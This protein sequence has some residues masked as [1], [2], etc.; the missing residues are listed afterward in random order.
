[1]GNRLILLVIAGLG[2]PTVLSAQTKDAGEIAKQ[3]KAIEAAFDK[4]NLKPAFQETDHLLVYAAMPKDKLKPVAELSQKSFLA[5]AKALNVEK[6]DE[7]FKGKMAA[8]LIPERRIYGNYIFAL[9]SRRPDARETSGFNIRSDA[10]YI[11]VS[12]ALGE[13]LSDSEFSEKLAT[14]TAIGVLNKKMGTV[15]D[16]FVLPE[17]A[18]EGFGKLIV[19]RADGLNSARMNT[20]KSRAKALVSGKARVAAKLS[21]AWSSTTRNK[22]YDTLVMSVV[23]YLAFGPDP[24]QFGKILFGFKKNDQNENPTMDSVLRSLEVKWEDMDLGWRRWV[25]TGK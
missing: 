6:P 17:W 9:D 20:Y 2:F 4:V 13:N 7:L 3:K 1:M 14:W 22:D 23:D 25:L 5:A 8:L 21:D 10:P 11:A 18:Q 24:E 19:A 16:S 12:K 15:P